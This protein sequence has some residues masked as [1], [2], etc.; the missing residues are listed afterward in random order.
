MRLLVVASA[1]FFATQLSW[2]LSR[3]FAG[4]AA[5][6]AIIGLGMV[7]NM[8]TPTWNPRLKTKIS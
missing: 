2:E 5:G 3:V 6:L 7:V 4:V 8:F 1:G